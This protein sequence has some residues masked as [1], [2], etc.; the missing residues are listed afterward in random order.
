MS[1]STSSTSQDFS[2]ASDSPGWWPCIQTDDWVII[3]EDSTLD[4]EEVA[5]AVAEGMIFPWDREHLEGLIDEQAVIFA[6]SLGVKE[7]IFFT[8]FFDC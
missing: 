6:L 5:M 2:S 1:A 8:N 7:N 3:V 4:N